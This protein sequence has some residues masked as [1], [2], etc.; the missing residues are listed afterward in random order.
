MRKEIACVT[1]LA[2]SSMPLVASEIDQLDD[3]TQRQFKA[4][5]EDLA[6]VAGYKATASAKP[7][8][9]IGFDVGVNL[10]AT[11]VES[12]SAWEEATGGDDLDTVVVPKLYARKG[13]PMDFDVGAFYVTVPGSNIE[14]WGAELQYAILDGGLASPALAVRGTHTGIFGVDDLDFTTTSMELV[15][16]KGFVFVTPY[17]GVGRQWT[18]STPQGIASDVGL[19]EESFSDMKYFVGVVV[20]PAVF[21]LSFEYDVTGEVSSASVKLGVKF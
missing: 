3:L 7:Q 19:D 17:A 18:V 9:I 12:A 14:A 13:L 15:L 6:A 5:S 20:A 21:N 11:Q 2:M 4:L 16:S 1:L 10:T 8:G